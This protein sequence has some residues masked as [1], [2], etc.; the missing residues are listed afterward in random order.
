MHEEQFL[1]AQHNSR[2]P[3]NAR[4]WGLPGGRL[5]QSE[6]PKSCLRR[7]LIEELDCRV[8]YLIRL[9][10]WRYG[11]EQQRVF[12]CEVE[13]RIV[14]FDQDELRAI[15]WF[16]YRDVVE[17]AATGKLRMGFELAAI[18]EF[19]RWCSTEPRLPARGKDAR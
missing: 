2:R 12:G 13:Q 3:E 8:P 15:R 6:K 11:E 1:L 17:L 10:D 5:K 7:E 9:G 19:R 4:K 18:A 14:T 16:S